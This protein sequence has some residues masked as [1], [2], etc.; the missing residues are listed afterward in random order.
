MLFQQAAFVGGDHH[1]D[2]MRAGRGACTNLACN[3]HPVDIG[4]APV[5]QE[6][7]V[8]LCSV[9]DGLQR[10]LSAGYG[11][12]APAK[13][14]GD[15]HQVVERCI[16]VVGDQYARHRFRRQDRQFALC[17]QWRGFFQRHH[18]I[19]FAAAAGHAF[20]FQFAAHQFDQAPANGQAQAAAA[21]TPTGGR[22]GLQERREDHALLFLGNTD[23]RVADRKQQL[24]LVGVAAGKTAYRQHHFAL[25][26]ELDRIADQV[27][28]HLVDAQR[29]AQQPTA[30]AREGFD[31]HFHRLGA[32]R[33]AHQVGDV[34]EQLVQIERCAFQVDTPGLDLGK[35]EDVVDDFQQRASGA[36]DLGDHVLRCAGQFAALKQVQHAQDGVHRRADFVAHVGQEI[37][38]GLVGALGR[39]HRQAQL[40]FVQ[41][42]LG[43]IHRHA[44]IADHLVV[45]VAQ[46]AQGQQHRQATPVMAHV[47]P[48]AGVAA[49]QAGERGDRFQR[50]RHLCAGLLGQ[51]VR[52]LLQFL[53][54]D[55][56]AG[57]ASPD[58][59]CRAVAQQF[60]GGR[61]E[62]RDE[63][64]GVGGD[65]GIAG[66]RQDRALQHRELHQLAGAFGD[67]VFERGVEVDDALM[68]AH[69]VGDVAEEM[70]MAAERAFALD[71][72][73]LAGQHMH[74]VPVAMAHG[75]RRRCVARQ[76]SI[77]MVDL[78]HRIRLR[79]QQR[80]QVLIDRL[81]GRV[82]EHRL[83]GRVPVRDT[84][85]R[86]LRNDGFAGMADQRGQLHLLAQYFLAAQPVAEIQHQQGGEQ[87]RGGHH[88]P[89]DQP[90]R[91]LVERGDEA[92]GGVGGND[93]GAAVDRQQPH[94]RRTQ[95]AVAGWRAAAIEIVGRLIAIGQVQRHVVALTQCA[96][97]HLFDAERR[98][99]PAAGGEH[100]LL[101]GLQRHAFPID[102]QQ[103]QKAAFV[104]NAVT[105][106]RD[107]RGHDRLAAAC[108]LQGGGAPARLG[109]DID[110]ER[111]VAGGF[112]LEIQHHVTLAIPRRQ[113]PA[114]DVRRTVGTRGL[115]KC[116]LVG[117]GDPMDVAVTQYPGKLAW[118]IPRAA[119]QGEAFSTDDVAACADHRTACAAQAMLEGGHAL[120]DVARQR[121]HHVVEPLLALELVLPL[122]PY[123]GDDGG[124]QA[125]AQNQQCTKECAPPVCPAQI[126]AALRHVRPFALP[127]TCPECWPTCVDPVVPPDMRRLCAVP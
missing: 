60:F 37:G 110:A 22:V 8:G 67:L 56:L 9:F 68:R 63:A 98:I 25:F 107:R 26:G 92:G 103:H 2:R 82:A 27:D 96:S 95:R 23:A 120:A 69:S 124:N 109:G 81:V 31:D 119:V 64:A 45:V 113:R 78:R 76:C 83:G 75:L 126:P 11:I 88:Q 108:G 57:L 66:V 49:P 71:D 87:D 4:H 5:E 12:H 111:A 10:G 18:E 94:H 41:L 7:I 28:Q 116:G 29:I 86:G 3:G 89:A 70:R 91:T 73:R 44:E 50:V 65:D 55:E 61:I 79:R 85:I 90:G 77:G 36:I 46:G 54:L 127:V 43:E 48:L 112:R 14:G 19:E 21:V 1:D 105:G 93:P 101:R 42:L 20:H 100:A 121:T 72:R 102:R 6:N 114:M 15:A 99:H 34:V 35:V 97:Y 122:Q 59:F 74:L 104:G 125:G 13:F 17:L 58:H 115:Q 24:E 84:S 53:L 33:G 38:L 80:G 62:Q 106:Q 52:A 118:I 47:G 32:E 30:V 51:H 39:I 16:V 40:F 123:A 117:R